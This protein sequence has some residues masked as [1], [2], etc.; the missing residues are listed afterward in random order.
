MLCE[1]SISV[2][3]VHFGGIFLYIFSYLLVILCLCLQEIV[4]SA[5][6]FSTS[7]KKPI[8]LV[9]SK[10]S[11]LGQPSRGDFSPISPRQ[12]VNQIVWNQVLMRKFSAEVSATD[13]IN[14]IKL[15]RERTSAPIKDVKTALVNCN[16]DLGLLQFI[17]LLCVYCCC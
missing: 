12:F 10:L 2:Q 11:A 4:L 1:T 8:W 14:R 13:Q 16:W 7:A 5:M 9:V 17:T 15:L 3:G 6:A